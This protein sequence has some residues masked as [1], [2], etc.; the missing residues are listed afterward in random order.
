M[1]T[2]LA[3]GQVIVALDAVPDS[4]PTMEPDGMG[5]EPLVG[6]VWVMLMFNTMPPGS[7]VSAQPLVLP[8]QEMMMSPKLPNVVGLA[9][10][11]LLE[12]GLKAMLTAPTVMLEPHISMLSQICEVEVE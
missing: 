4:E 1:T 10:T 8:T 9:I 6:A 7:N 12:I 2:V 5:P 3:A 11:V